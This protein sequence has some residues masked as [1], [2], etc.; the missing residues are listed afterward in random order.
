MDS[1]QKWRMT[2]QRSQ[3]KL[4]EKSSQKDEDWESYSGRDNLPV[5]VWTSLGRTGLNFDQDHL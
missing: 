4:S 3:V 1:K 5:E 2:L